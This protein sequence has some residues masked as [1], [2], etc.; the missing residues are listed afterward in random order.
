MKLKGQIIASILFACSTLM[1]PATADAEVVRLFSHKAWTVS[2]VTFASGRTACT[3]GTRNGNGDFFDIRVYPGGGLATFIELNNWTSDIGD[4]DVNMVLD[5]DYHRWTLLD[6]SLMG[7]SF[8]FWFPNESGTGQFNRQLANGNAIALKTWNGKHTMATW[9]L[10]G[11]S[12]AILAFRECI[13]R[14]I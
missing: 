3:A 7:N 6:T 13:A 8:M 10:A 14:I 11:S 12:A 1:A 5:V 9:S 2:Y 4:R